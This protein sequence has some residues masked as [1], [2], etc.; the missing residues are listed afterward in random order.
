MA[1]YFVFSGYCAAVYGF[2][3]LAGAGGKWLIATIGV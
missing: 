1:I 2:H 3:F